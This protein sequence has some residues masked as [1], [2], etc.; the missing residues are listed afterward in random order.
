MSKS[1]SDVM[2]SLSITYSFGGI[3]EDG[4]SILG[5]CSSLLMYCG[6]AKSFSEKYRK[7][8]VRGLL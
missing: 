7:V 2:W 8:I 4:L 6:V 3:I 1:N 5:C